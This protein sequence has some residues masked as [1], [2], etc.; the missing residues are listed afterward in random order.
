MKRESE[1]PG[2]RC[3]HHISRNFKF[4]SYIHHRDTEHVDDESGEP[5][6][7]VEESRDCFSHLWLLIGDVDLSRE[8]FPGRI[9]GDDRD[10]LVTEA[11]LRRGEEGGDLGGITGVATGRSRDD[12][13]GDGETFVSVD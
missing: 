2:V 13:D 1:E 4:S 8:T 3:V 9:I 5:T 11:I 10:G 12:D 7:G 6:R